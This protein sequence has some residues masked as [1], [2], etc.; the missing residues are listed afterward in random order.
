MVTT[1]L[2][3]GARSVPPSHTSMTAWL[4]CAVFASCR[5]GGHAAS[6]AGSG[7]L[8]LGVMARLLAPIATLCAEVFGSY[9]G[10]RQNQ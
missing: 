1:G 6:L 8:S 2:H 5:D 10:D 3:H 4:A 9:F 7:L